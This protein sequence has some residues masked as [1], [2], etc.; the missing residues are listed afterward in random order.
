VTRRAPARAETRRGDAR[1]SDPGAATPGAATPGA[2]T[3]GADA[4]RS[5]ARRSDARRSD[6]RR[7]DAR[8]G[9]L[10][11]PG[12][13]GSLKYQRSPLSGLSQ[14][15][16]RALRIADNKIALNAGWYLEILHR[17][18]GELASM[19]ILH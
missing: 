7:G 13:W 19:S 8:R 9:S 4:R 16:K 3:L 10:R 11:P 2:A 15:Q 17:E 18:L 12:R 5:D 14:T 6:A 1:R